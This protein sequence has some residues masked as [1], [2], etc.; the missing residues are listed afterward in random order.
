MRRCTT[1]LL[2]YCTTVTELAKYGFSAS[3]PLISNSSVAESR[4]IRFAGGYFVKTVKSRSAAWCHS[5]LSEEPQVA[6]A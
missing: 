1:V 4:L 3:V 5:P 2:Y 6:M